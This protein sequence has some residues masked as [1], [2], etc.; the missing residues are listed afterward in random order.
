MTGASSSSCRLQGVEAVLEGVGFVGG[1][2]VTSDLERRLEEVARTF[3]TEL[4][5]GDVSHEAEAFETAPVVVSVAVLAERR[6][7]EVLCPIAVAA[8][9][10]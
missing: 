10:R 9:Q 3:G 1:A 6:A 7:G 4:D 2:D 8:S 5:D